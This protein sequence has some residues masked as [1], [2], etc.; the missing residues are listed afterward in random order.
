MLCRGAP[1]SVTKGR[2]L[3]PQALGQKLNVRFVLTGRVI[4]RGDTLLV[5]T[6]M[7]DV[8]KGSQLWGEAKPDLL[9]CTVFIRRRLVD[10]R[11]V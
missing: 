1:C 3:D 2:E 8:A 11:K 6:E 5:G 9:G 10:Y 7:M 4:H